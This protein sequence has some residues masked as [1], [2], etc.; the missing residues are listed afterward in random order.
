MRLRH[1]IA[2]LLIAAGLFACSANA[3]RAPF[4]PQG[5]THTRHGMWWNLGTTQPTVDGSMVIPVT[6]SV[7]GSVGT[8]SAFG[9]TLC[10]APAGTNPCP[11]VD[12]AASPPAW[13]SASDT[14]LT[15]A[16]TTLGVSCPTACYIVAYENGAG[17]YLVQGPGAGQTSASVTLGTQNIAL[18]FT[19]NTTYDF[20]LAHVTAVNTPPPPPTPSPSP[21]PSAQPTPTPATRCDDDGE[22][23]YGHTGAGKHHHRPCAED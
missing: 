21:S 1:C 15:F 6:L 11:N 8:F 22:E 7:S 13:T 2:A 9:S 14:S 3:P 16:G 17:P 12:Y 5:T 18:Y 20:F 4:L 19:A 23:H 10:A